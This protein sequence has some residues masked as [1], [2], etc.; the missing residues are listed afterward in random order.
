[1]SEIGNKYGKLTVIDF[2]QERIRG[3]VS[4]LCKCECGNEIV[5]IG[6]DLRIGKKTQCGCQGHANK[7]ERYNGYVNVNAVTLK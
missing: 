1:M 5:V 6:T 7:K 4:W 3:R 2:S